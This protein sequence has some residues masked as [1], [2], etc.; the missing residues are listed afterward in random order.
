MSGDALPA[1]WWGWVEP[2]RAES[3]LRWLLVLLAVA[4]AF[5]ALQGRAARTLLMGML[6]ATLATGF[7]CASLARPYGLFEDPRVTRAAAAATLLGTRGVAG[8]I[9]PDTAFVGGAWAR[10]AGLGI[11]EALLVNGPTLLPALVLP[12]SALLVH[13]LWRAPAA[14]LAALLWLAFSTGG[15]DALRGTGFVP[16]LWARPASSL[17]LLTVLAAL[18]VLE[19]ARHAASRL[20]LALGAVASAVV[21]LGTGDLRLDGAAAAAAIALDP[22]PWWLPA[23][24]AW[25]RA[26]VAPRALVA[27]G[28]ALLGAVGLG[29]PL[30][31]WGA[32]ALLRVG[33]VLLAA[34]TLHGLLAP[35]GSSAAA[36]CARLPC[37]VAGRVR[38]SDLALGLLLATCVPGSFLV[39]WAPLKLDPVAHASLTRPPDGLL[40]AMHWVRATTPPGAV[41]VTGSR[42]ADGVPVL[43]GRRVLRAPTLAPTP[44]D[45]R[46]A[47]L[48][49]LAVAGRA[50]EGWRNA[51]RYRITHLLLGPGDLD[52]F[53]IDL[54]NAPAAPG[55]WRLRFEARDGFRVY[56]LIHWSASHPHGA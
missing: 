20:A 27:C 44:D 35:L 1:L 30:D 37:R 17:A 50:G 9:A 38:P 49:Y 42:W 12:L 21:L 18:F 56:E 40:E 39:W 4:W 28:A 16:G 26:G 45:A 41:F 15:L 52:E 25:R 6:F 43:G 22:W 53:G 13:A 10:L 48:A 19:R 8:G 7:W 14:P 47:R 32:Q 3:S 36:A 51:R 11:P 2:A 23:L 33:L 31:A 55:R 5:V 34:Q 46:R 29:A 54:G 24:P